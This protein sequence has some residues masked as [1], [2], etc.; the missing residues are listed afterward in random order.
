MLKNLL[1]AGAVVVSGSVFMA[2]SAEAFGHHRRGGHGRSC[3]S[4]CGGGYVA[5]PAVVQQPVSSGC[6]GAD[7]SYG[8]HQGY[9]EGGYSQGGVYQGQSQGGNYYGQGYSQPYQSGYRYGNQGYN[10]Q[11]NYG[12]GYRGT[13]VGVG[14][15][16]G[17]GGLGRSV[18]GRVLGGV[19]G[20]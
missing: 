15:G 19:G 5:Q 20:W 2:Q 18:G 8:G 12:S 7:Q 3:C 14:V 17:A 6:C 13:G 11:G 9:N 1:L 16:V 4:P 10:G